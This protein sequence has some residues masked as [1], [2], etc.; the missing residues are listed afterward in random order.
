MLNHGNALL[1]SHQRVLMCE[2]VR[3][4]GWT[5][6]EAA[7]AFGVSTRSVFRWLRRFDAVDAMTDWSSVPP[8]RRGP[9]P[10]G[11][12]V[13]AVLKRLGVDR[14]PDSNHPNLR[15]DTAAVTQAS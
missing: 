3:H 12:T 15:S 14:L 11:A 2:R 13:Y 9:H 7:A 5:M 10:G 8:C 4:K 6:A 1:L